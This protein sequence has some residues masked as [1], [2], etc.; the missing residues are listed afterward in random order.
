MVSVLASSR[1][2][3]GF[4]PRLGQTTDYEIGICKF[5]S[6]MHATLRSKIIECLPH[7]HNVS[8]R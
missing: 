2:D 3:R 7:N 6:A 4:E 1:V 5:F 8:E